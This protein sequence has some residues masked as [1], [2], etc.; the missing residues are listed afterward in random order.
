MLFN[1]LI[2]S[3]K[4]NK[5]AHDFKRMFINSAEGVN[6]LMVKLNQSDNEEQLMRNLYLVCLICLETPKELKVKVI[7]KMD[8]LYL[9]DKVSILEMSIENQKNLIS[10]LL[11][12]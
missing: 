5:C 4:Y 9:L 10:Y 2:F 1:V 12:M 8:V 11:E 7:N 6:S 3:D